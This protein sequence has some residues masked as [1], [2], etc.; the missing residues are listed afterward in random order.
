M[1][2]QTNPARRSSVQYPDRLMES[3]DAHKD[4]TATNGTAAQYMN[5]SVFSMIAA[6]GSKADFH[7]RFDET[8]SDS[9]G[10][11]KDQAAKNR[12]ASRLEDLNP[13]KDA[14]RQGDGQHVSQ[15]MQV[16]RFDRVDRGRSRDFRKLNLSS[17]TERSDMSG[18]T[19]L[20]PPKASLISPQSSTSLAHP[21]APIMSRMV[22]A[23]SQVDPDDVPDPSHDV[24]STQSGTADARPDSKST[25]RQRLKEIFGFETEEDV[26]AGKSM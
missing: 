4:V 2:T 18:G 12:S 19:I 22:Q 23:Q 20:P 21:E 15:S 3:D 17:I 9:E 10:E 25:L 14:A 6:A 11:D 13:R 7:A 26:T 24:A 1:A 5:Q 16:G 8:S